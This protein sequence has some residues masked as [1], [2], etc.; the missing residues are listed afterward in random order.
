MSGHEAYQTIE[1]RR[2][3]RQEL[4]RLAASIDRKLTDEQAEAYWAALKQFKLEDVKTAVNR[5]IATIS[6]R[7]FPTVAVMIDEVARAKG[8]RERWVPHYCPICD[9]TGIITITR[10]GYE[11]AKRCRCPNG[12]KHSHLIPLAEAELMEAN[13]PKNERDPDLPTVTEFDVENGNVDKEYPN[14]CNMVRTCS[15]CGSVVSST[16][17]R[18]VDRDEVVYRI[19][20]FNI[21]DKCFV[22]DGR[23]K[24]LWR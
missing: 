11:F 10:D 20:H 6:D 15:Q 18:R 17:Y 23:R 4:E 3:L 8:E 13:I 22:G 2:A 12:M 1:H 7:S 9:C 19:K 21:C 5:M 14:G 24:G 16:T